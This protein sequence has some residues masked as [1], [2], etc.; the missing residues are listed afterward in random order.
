MPMKIEEFIAIGFF[1]EEVAKNARRI[2][3]LKRLKCTG[4]TR[5]TGFLNLFL[6][7]YLIINYDKSIR[8]PR[9]HGSTSQK[10]VENAYAT[11]SACA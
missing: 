3:I 8:I 5:C 7:T 6:D 9:E 4:F 11:C 1:N 2:I 10:K